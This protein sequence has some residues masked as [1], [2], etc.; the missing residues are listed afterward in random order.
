MFWGVLM[1]SALQGFSLLLMTLQKRQ[2][3][4]SFCF[5]CAVNELNFN[6]LHCEIFAMV[7]VDDQSSNSLEKGYPVKW[8]IDF[9]I[10]SAV[11]IL[12]L[13]TENVLMCE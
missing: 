13:H 2:M 12:S 3:L 1:L 8:F 11:I 5:F 6:T 7:V 9:Q 4:S 10:L